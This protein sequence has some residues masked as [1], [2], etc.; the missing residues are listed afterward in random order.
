MAKPF[1]TKS[2]EQFKP[3]KTRR[4][5]QDGGCTGLYLF[6]QALP[7]GSKSWK[8]LLTPPNGG[9]PHKLHLGSLDLSGV[10]AGGFI[11]PQINTPLTLAGARALATELYRQRAVGKDVVADYKNEKLIRKA[12]ASEPDSKFAAVAEQ[13]IAEHARPNTRRWKETAHCLGLDYPNEDDEPIRLKG[14]LAEQ[15]CDREISSITSDDVYRVVDDTK[16][17]GIPGLPRRTKGISNSR[18][19]AMA[20]VLS[21]LF[22]WTLEHRKIKA[23]PSIGVFVPPA[24]KNRERVLSQDEIV[25]FWRATNQLNEPFG[26]MLRVLLLTAARLR[27]VAGMRRSELSEDG[28]IWT[29]PANRT[30][31]KRAHII[32][33]PP[34]ARDIIGEV[35]QIKGQGGFVFS[36]TGSTPVSGFSKTKVRLDELMTDG[37]KKDNTI[38]AWRLHDL[39]RS[40][41][42]M[43]AESPP[44]GLGIQPHIVEAILNHVS[45][46]K[47]GVAGVYN[48]ASYL[49]EKTA[50]LQRWAA[51]VEGMVEG[52]PAN[53]TALSSGKKKGK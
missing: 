24:P 50:A 9:K 19:R 11:S 40:A 31:N 33:L 51:H 21:K 28:T 10:E 29:I 23:S 13:F 43:M 18:G 1:T 52:R 30:K 6:V 44:K 35:K 26:S 17:H 36:T 46:H 34:L 5:I 42:T 41:A 22:G 4:E 38:P 3:G 20:R 25:R 16:R 32:P 12:K 2:I 15:W 8:L 7:S 45:G 49:P 53:V 47:V 48:L 39:R 14:G 37:A 27:E